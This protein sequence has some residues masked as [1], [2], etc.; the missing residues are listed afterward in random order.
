M[1]KIA[2]ALT[3]LAVLGGTSFALVGN[4]TPAS[5]TG[6]SPEACPCPPE[7]C[8]DTGCGEGSCG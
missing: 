8:V 6:C 4:P 5:A 7:C 1:K 2:I 3:A